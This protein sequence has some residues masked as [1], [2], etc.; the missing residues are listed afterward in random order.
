MFNFVSLDE[1]ISKITMFEQFLMAA[2]GSLES[3]HGKVDSVTADVAVI[4]ASKGDVGSVL[5]SVTAL[6]DV[7][8]QG[9]A[10]LGAVQSLHGEVVAAIPV[11]AVKPTLASDQG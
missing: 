8:T 4:K 5:N 1:I 11:V 3:L 10:I 7:L 9:A 6:T 2:A